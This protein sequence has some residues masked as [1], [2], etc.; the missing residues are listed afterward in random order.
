MFPFVVLPAPLGGDQCVFP[1]QSLRAEI[2]IRPRPRPL[3]YSFAFAV[4][5]V[6]L[7]C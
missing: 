5:L 2:E 6:V 4:L 7:M 3:L 1:Q